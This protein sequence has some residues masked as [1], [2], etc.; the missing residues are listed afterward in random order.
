MSRNH[1]KA[2]KILINLRAI[3]NY[4]EET[5]TDVIFG[6][7]FNKIKEDF[8]KLLGSLKAAGAELVFTSKH[9]NVD[10]YED[11]RWKSLNKDYESGKLFVKDLGT[12]ELTNVVR[13]SKISLIAD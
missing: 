13:T 8:E 11:N 2:P 3:N 10:N 1:D 6:C 4:Y 7:R 12:L 5:L 9:S